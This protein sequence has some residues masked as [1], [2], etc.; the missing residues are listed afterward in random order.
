M[1]TPGGGIKHV[2]HLGS[3]DDVLLPASSNI[4]LHVTVD[5]SH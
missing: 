1:K 2:G 3:S 5:A 4:T